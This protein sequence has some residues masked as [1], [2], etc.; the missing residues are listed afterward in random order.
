MPIEDQT[1]HCGTFMSSLR[2][3]SS[4]SII[5]RAW[6]HAN[7]TSK[8]I[9]HPN[10]NPN[11]KKLM[12]SPQSPNHNTLETTATKELFAPASVLGLGILD[13][14]LTLTLACESFT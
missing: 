2:D 10:P 12:T 11:Q 9:M 6:A 5:S 8:T 13:S 14:G 3:N 7:V 4:I 1:S